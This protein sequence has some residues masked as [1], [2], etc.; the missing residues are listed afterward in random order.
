MTDQILD[1]SDV[2][3]WVTSAMQVLAATEVEVLRHYDSRYRGKSLCVISQTDTL[4][5]PVKELKV[6]LKHA[7][8]VLSCYFADIVA[9]SARLARAGDNDQMRP[10]YD[11][12]W[13]K[14][15]PKSQSI[16]QQSVISD[17][18]SL[19]DAMAKHLR[20]NAE[21]LTGL[22]GDLESLESRAMKALDDFLTYLTRLAGETSR[23][24]GRLRNEL[25]SQIQSDLTTWTDYEPFTR[26]IE[27]IIWD[28]HVVDYREIQRWKWPDE[29][30]KIADKR[31]RQESGEIMTKFVSQCHEFLGLGACR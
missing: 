6:L 10:F 21:T 30:T 25:V 2:I 17:A 28:D 9:V 19:V 20:G 3:I 4:D 1:E 18:V 27:G 14:I 12:F 26:T 31:I 11:S 8:Q 7:K 13:K 22:L 23:T 5:N 24:F 15:V 16:K 29:A